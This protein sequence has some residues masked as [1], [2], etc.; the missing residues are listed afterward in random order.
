MRSALAILTL[1]LLALSCSSDEQ[2]VA[3]AVDD[4]GAS[5]S[6]TTSTTSE[7]AASTSSTT[8]TSEAPAT[9]TTTVET[10]TTTTAPVMSDVMAEPGMRSR[11]SGTIDGDIAITVQLTQ[12]DRFLLGELVYDA[13]GEPIPVIGDVR[14]GSDLVVLHEFALDGSV[15]GTLAFND[16]GDRTEPL[17]GFW[18]D[19][20][21]ELR[22]EGVDDQPYRFEAAVRSGEYRYQ[23]APFGEGDEE[24]W[25][26]AGY[27]AIAVVEDGASAVIEIQNH[28]GA[29]G[30]NQAWI[31]PIELAVDGNRLVFDSDEVDPALF[32]GLDCA[33]EVV[34]FDTFAF[35]EYLD[36]RWDCAFG[37]GA[38]V[39]GVFVLTDPVAG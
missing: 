15:T 6:S 21:L 33:F 35:V 19:L 30:Y 37:F 26:P 39:S 17:I 14:P 8:T 25:G 22:Y 20:T 10:T 28:R 3:N 18:N 34:V 24:F 7:A 13:V 38:G 12:Q 4:D 16:P 23:F 9:T 11:W 32:D 2:T 29:P 1:S 31:E 36:D 5:A 27:L